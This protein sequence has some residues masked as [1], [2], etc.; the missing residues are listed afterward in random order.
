M[1]HVLSAVGLAAALLAPAA[2][3]QSFLE[4]VNATASGRTNGSSQIVGNPVDYA[5]GRLRLTLDPRQAAT[6]T[7][8]YLYESAEHGVGV[9]N[10]F[11]GPGGYSLIDSAAPLNTAITTPV[12]SGLLDFAFLTVGELNMVSNRSNYAWNPSHFGIALDAN[13]LGGR[14]LFEDGAFGSGGMDYDDMVIR[15]NLNVAPVPEASS[16]AM[17]GAGG[18]VLLLAGRA[19]R[20]R[21]V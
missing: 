20:R 4:V 12:V 15:F 21:Q 10:Q 1:K 14:L 16:I 11:W 5:V 13:G 18:L 7:I 2:H 6:A 17:L 3:A 8:T 9:H 19:R